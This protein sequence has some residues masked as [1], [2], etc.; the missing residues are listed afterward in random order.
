MD[1][2]IRLQAHDRM[3]ENSRDDIDQR[4]CREIEVNDS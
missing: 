4:G 1:R 3:V 2:Q